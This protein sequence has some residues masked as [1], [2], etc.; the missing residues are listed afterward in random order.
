MCRF[1][2][3]RQ[4]PFISL[5]F[6]A[7]PLFGNSG[8][9]KTIAGTGQGG[10][11]ASGIPATS[12]QLVGPSGIALDTANDIFIAD[13]GNNRVVAIQASTGTLFQAVGTGVASSTG[14]GG[15]A[16]QATLNHPMGVAMDPA[17]NLYISEPA[18]HRIRR[19][20]VQ[21][22]IIMTVV[23]TGTAGFSG[24]G[25]PA[26]AAS[27]NNP[28]GIAFD[29]AGNLYIADMG[30]AR[31][32]LVNGQTGIITTIA[33]NGTNGVSPDGVPAISAS[34]SQP[35]WVAV[36]PSGGLLL[37]ELGANRVRRVDFSS[38]LLST[39]A[40]NGDA[41][42]EGDGVPATSTGIGTAAGIT[43]DAHNNLYIAD[44]TGRV[45]IVNAVTGLITTVA[46][47]G[48]GAHGSWSTSGGTSGPPCYATVAG[49]NGPATNATL[50]GAFGLQVVPGSGNLL[51]ADNLDCR[52]RA[53]DLP[54][55]YPYTNTTLASSA[56][57]L[58]AGQS[59]VL[60]ATVTPIGAGGVPTGMITFLDSFGNSLKTVSLNG[61]TASFLLGALASTTTVTAIYSGDTSFNGSGSPPVAL[62]LSSASKNVTTV[63]L[64]ADQTPS[65]VNA[66][67][68][69]T[70]T[71]PASAGAPAPTGPVFLYDGSSVVAVAN[72]ANGVATLP[73]VFTTSGYHNITATYLGDNNYSQVSSAIL[74]QPVGTI[75]SQVTITSNS[76]SSTYGQALTFTVS[77]TPSSAT[78]TIQL[79]VDQTTTYSSP[80]AN[81]QAIISVPALGAGTHTIS[82]SYSGDS[83]NSPATSAPFPQ[84]VAQA[85]PTFTLTSS[86]NPSA[87]GQPVTFTLTMT[88]ASTG[89]ALG[90][91]ISN[92]P[93]NL[94]ATWSTGMTSVTTANLPAGSHTV[95]GSWPGDANVLAGTAQPLVQTVQAAATTTT[96][97]AAPNPSVYGGSVTL[98]ATV[99]PTAASG[100]VS[101][102]DNGTLLGAGNVVSGQAQLSIATLPVGSNTLTATYG[103]DAIYG[104]SSSTAVT[105]IV[106]PAS[107]PTTVALVSSAN[108]SIAG[109]P[110]WLTATISPST[111]TGTVQFLDGASVLG[112]GTIAS[113]W[114]SLQLTSLTAGTH[115]IT[116]AYSGD[117]NDLAGTSAVLS[118]ALSPASP[119]SVQPEII[120]TLTG[121][122]NGCA[123]GVQ[124][125][126]IASPTADA[127]GNLYFWQ[128]YQI[129]K[130]APDGTTTPIAG[131]GQYGY[132]GDGGPALAAT[133]SGNQ[134][135]VHGTRL[136]FGSF[137][138]I[139]C[140]D[141]STGLIQGY[142]T[143]AQGSSGDGGNVAN[144]SFNA[145]TGA[146]F[147]DAG[148]LYISDF[149]ANNVRRIDATTSIVTTFAGP[150]PGYSGAPLGDGGPA[151]GA[152][153]LEPE[154]LAYY[155]GGIYIADGNDE[156]RRVDLATGMITSV[157]PSYTQN[158][159]ID[160][161]GDIF[162]RAGLTINMIDPSG[163]VTAI[164]D[165]NNYSGVGAD[166]ILATNTTFGGMSG[167]GYDPVAK[168]L[169]I[170]D[171]SRLRQIFFTPPTTTT[172]TAS[173]N[174][175]APGG[176]VTLEANV[177]PATATGSVRFYQ[178]SS[179]LGSAP[180]ANGVADYTWTAPAP[181]SSTVG[182][183]AVYGGDAND[184][185]STSATVTV[186]VQQGTTPTTTT[187][188]SSPNPSL[189]GAPVQLS[190]SV[191]PA[192]ATGSVS[193]YAN[194]TLLGKVALVGGQA[195]F[196]ATTLPAG[197]NL[198]MAVYS[199]DL[200]YAVT[201]SN[202]VTQIVAAAPSVTLASSLNPSTSG[203]AVSFTASIVPAS[204]TGTVQF[205]DGGTVLGTSTISGGSAALSVSTLTVGTHSITAV[206][207]GDTNNPGATSAALAQTVNKAASSVTLTS[208]A[209]PA[210]AGQ[211]LTLTAA[212][213]PATATGTVQFLDAGTV[214]GTATITNG[215]AVFSL[216][217]LS[218]DT[219]SITAVYSGD[220]TYLGSTSAV[221]TQTV[222]K[223][224][225]SVVLVLSQTPAPYGQSIALSAAVTPN[226]AT[227]TVQFLDGATLL[228]T[229]PVTGGTATMSIATLSVGPHVIT[230][231]YS[232][233]AMNATSTSSAAT[234]TINPRTSAVALTSSANPSV[235]GQTVTFSAS[236]TPAAA[237]GTVQF[238]DGSTVLGTV[239]VANGSAAFTTA[240]LTVGTHSITA[241]YSGDTND[242]PGASTPTSLVVQQAPTTT[243]LTSNTNRTPQ[244]QGIPMSVAVSPSSATGNVNL[245][246][247]TT[248]IATSALVNGVTAF[249]VANLPVGSNS[250]YA[251]YL[252]DTSYL[253][254]S[255]AT[256]VQVVLIPTSIVLTTA[257]NPSVYGAPVTLTA[258]ASPSS[259]T[260][261]VQFNS[262]NTIL[263]TASLVNGKAALSIATLPA[264]QS[265]LMAYYSGDDTHTAFTSLV[266][267]QTVNKA[268]SRVTVTSSE[269]PAVTGDDVTFAAAVLPVSATGTVQFLDGSTVLGTATVSGGSATLAVSTLALGAHSIKAVYSGDTN[270]VGSTSPVLKQTV[271]RPAHACHVTYTVTGQWNGGFGTSIS[272]QN[273]GTAAVNDWNLSWIWPDNQNITQSW[274]AAYSQ[275]GANVKLTNMSYN[276]TIAPGATL[277]GIGFNASYSGT[278]GAPTAF[279]LNG[280]LCN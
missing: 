135:A 76:P 153:L 96:L 62:T 168:R 1:R 258:A 180:L 263:G 275:T 11:L 147:D 237:T 152:N 131:N 254:S 127:A 36:N 225:T 120:T 44:V 108:P 159:A 69:F 100:L 193:F 75:S 162:F 207:S 256:V 229:A 51:I 133:V 197:S 115:S 7:S 210:T 73:V 97:A 56:T 38:G 277:K 95:T 40:G 205:L 84:T 116:A 216:S 66:T 126:R 189:P 211:A 172:L 21:T 190:V 187:L 185:L 25:G 204:V 240:T 6:L 35:F 233:D 110:L 218:A 206:Y 170:A 146:A 128:G 63:T 195:Q 81:G 53:V 262:G 199:G 280:T 241:S 8:L 276:A 89:A 49:D 134:L 109:R 209:N 119:P 149:A 18:G 130:L 188:T 141:L 246:N 242:S 137:Y 235:F 222:N 102:F 166:D 90:L 111:A 93:A 178:N 22:G 260:G 264:G 31:I 208:S 39:V 82:A 74:A 91:Q 139:R 177:T 145:P 219:H 273:T 37:S 161:S 114:T 71:V 17:G 214:L 174:P 234:E 250:V 55:P 182:M 167:L 151:V 227:G 158:I 10:S 202:G 140:V 253:P 67:T 192:A 266:V 181:G 61:G 163:N 191:S 173:P 252:G 46:G 248:V 165:S 45:R 16:A 33:G 257:P 184:N 249:N 118:Q 160:P 198:L 230:A 19:V 221:L 98:T 64:S 217:T 244:G 272:I 34:L 138:K 148:N 50:D 4:A 200:T 5:F 79:T 47:N 176:Q 175:V 2:V 265:P 223:V 232:G 113:G 247:G 179:L 157:T 278:N 194:G 87:A 30:N 271:N 58:Q 52:I 94:Q 261:P 196:S 203:Q 183:R 226:S 259:A 121:S 86:L 164:A 92:P 106:T 32:R 215:G 231:V 15:P 77:V 136:C 13:S 213:T 99:Q 24:D 88:P 236:L 27:L 169:L 41:I 20:N 54:S 224:A 80:L 117:A 68:T 28:T 112:R 105:Q 124:Y 65:P 78:G 122:P 29:S 269:N 85:T 186:A 155:N 9:I 255:S 251:R 57:T 72:L 48:T 3:S 243:T 268:P 238:V 150:G 125:C 101:F 23:G 239:S 42:F 144:A 12:A 212:V 59:A 279:S 142:G 228:G 83:K 171:Q 43:L 107:N 123:P 60:T 70:A 201:T 274:N 129:M 103:G 154:D 132:S 156:I 245:M 267:T 104:S 220:G 143:G 270:Y 26:Q 14:D